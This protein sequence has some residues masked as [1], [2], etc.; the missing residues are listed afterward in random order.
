MLNLVRTLSPLNQ[1]RDQQPAEPAHKSCDV[2]YGL[3]ADRLHESDRGNSRGPFRLNFSLDQLKAAVDKRCICCSVLFRGL[4][5]LGSAPFLATPQPQDTIFLVHIADGQPLR[6]K[7]YRSGHSEVLGEFEYYTQK[8]CEPSFF[9]FSHGLEVSP[10]VLSRENVQMIKDWTQDCIR[11][12]TRCES[13]EEG[14]LPLRVINVGTVDGA[15]PWLEE[16]FGEKRGTYVALSHCWGG[17]QPLKTTLATRARRRAEIEWSLLPKTFQD[18]IQITRALGI[19]YIWIDSLC[20]VQ[21]DEQDWAENAAQMGAIFEGSYITL[22]ATSAKDS[23]VGCFTSRTVATDKAILSAVDIPG[24]PSA[25]VHV[26][27]VRGSAAHSWLTTANPDVTH[28]MNA[29]ILGRGWCFQERLLASRVVH[30]ARDE[31]VFEC[32][33]RCRCECGGADALSFKALY[34]PMLEQGKPVADLELSVEALHNEIAALSM[35]L[36]KQK[37]RM[38]VEHYSTRNFTHLRDV[39]PALSALASRHDQATND[40][41]LAGLWKSQMPMDLLWYSKMEKQS[42]RPLERANSDMSV[43]TEDGNSRIYTAPTFSWASRIGPVTWISTFDSSKP[44]A[45]LVDAQCTP[46]SHDVFGEVEDGF[47]R[48]RGPTLPYSA[49]LF[50]PPNSPPFTSLLQ[51]SASGSCH[52]DTRD[53]EAIARKAPLRLLC[54]LKDERNALYRSV[55]VATALILRPS[56]ARK[57]TY[58][59][60]GILQWCDATIFD[61]ASEMDVTIV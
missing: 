35:G 37:W 13:L 44:T 54:V 30:F 61:E 58:R 59:R 14:I 50:D 23:T 32:K 7:A 33:S 17:H 52:F 15:R 34:V 47:V 29:P 26:R 18:A 22:S 2:C 5:N 49:K 8:G 10:N 28:R 36:D 4:E 42:F 38:L 55:D 40:T 24:L 11:H 1:L 46:R 57:G 9:P 27:P 53:G 12:H 60:L 3:D 16:T 48:L 20:I 51:N 6:L 43:V 31:I 25:A 21:D 45:R 39:L 41:Y 19:S 56:N